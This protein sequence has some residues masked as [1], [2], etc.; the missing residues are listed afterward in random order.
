MFSQRLRARNIL[1]RKQPA[2]R[3]VKEGSIKSLF[4][5]LCLLPSA[6]LVL[7]G[8]TAQKQHQD[9]APAASSGA[10]H[11]FPGSVHTPED[12]RPPGRCPE[13]GAVSGLT[14]RQA[15][16]FIRAGPLSEW[17]NHFNSGELDAISS[18]ESVIQGHPGRL[19]FGKACDQAWHSTLTSQ[20]PWPRGI[21]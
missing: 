7:Q 16:K 11:C 5:V 14:E 18:K 20:P 3:S 8:Q 21:L 12:H 2:G 10:D 19:R 9:Q 17:A 15:H 6:S 4:S 1:P 13:E